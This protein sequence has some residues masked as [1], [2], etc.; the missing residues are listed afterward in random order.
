MVVERVD[1][2]PRLRRA[3]GL[4]LRLGG[5]SSSAPLPGEASADA[6]PGRGAHLDGV[7]AIIQNGATFTYFQDRPIEIAEDV[8][9]DSGALA[10]GVLHRATLLSMPSIAWR[11]LSR[12]GRVLG[13]RQVSAL[14]ELSELTVRSTDGRGLP[15][16]ADGDYLGE[17]AEARYSVLPDALQIVC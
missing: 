12:R 1:A 15:L 8:E 5:V 6:R 16:Q 7:L 17:V 9:L 11:A 10:G 14:A 13:H 2:N 3:W 4:L